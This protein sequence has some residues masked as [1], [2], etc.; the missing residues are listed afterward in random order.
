MDYWF[1]RRLT[2]SCI[3]RTESTPPMPKQIHQSTMINLCGSTSLTIPYPKVQRK[4]DSI[5][6]QCSL[7]KSALART[8]KQY[9]DYSPV[10]QVPKLMYPS[11]RRVESYNIYPGPIGALCRTMKGAGGQSF[12]D[13]EEFTTQ[14][15]KLSVRKAVVVRVSP[16][17][18]RRKCDLP[19]LAFD[20]FTCH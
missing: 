15:E 16:Y 14:L 10:Y 17:C 9:E 3:S 13:W 4:R 19:P 6:S 18:E 20:V 2:I 12:E 8:A 1:I 7:T 11:K 5:A